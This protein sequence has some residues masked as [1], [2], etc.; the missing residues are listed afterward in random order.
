MGALC[1]DS[2]QLV[3]AADESINQNRKVISDEPSILCDLQDKCISVTE[4]N[5]EHC[6]TTA[7]NKMNLQNSLLN[8]MISEFDA[9]YK[10]SKEELEKEYKDRFEYLMS[11]MPILFRNETNNMLKYNNKN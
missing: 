7:T 6:E 1:R 8:D 2:P 4:K 3:R 10:L 11:I 9:K 5:Q